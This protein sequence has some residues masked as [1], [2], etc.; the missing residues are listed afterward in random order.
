[1][2]RKQKLGLETSATRTLLLDTAEELMRT[3]GYAA[4]T[5]RR[6]G[7]AAGVKPQL[8]HYYFASMDDLFVTLY[9]RRAE[10]VLKLA[11]DAL[12]S[13][14]VLRTLWTQSSDPSDVAINLEF[15]ALGNHRKAVRAEA[16]K[17]GEQ[18]RAMQHKALVRYLR[19]H[20]IKPPVPPSALIV[21]LASAGLLLVLESDA[22]MKF[23]HAE[24]K[25]VVEAALRSLEGKGE[26]ATRPRQVV[27]RK[28]QRTA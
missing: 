10:R 14:Q 21:L 12:Q 4:V 6:L 3:E 24:A 27:R 26:I 8:A 18:L 7:T 2:A 9:R 23:G 22:G 17:C 5:S 20:K 16:V 15:M 19:Q 1:M 11:E 13:D 25:A 28:R